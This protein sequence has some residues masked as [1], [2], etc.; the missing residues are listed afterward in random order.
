MLCFTLSYVDRQILSFLIEPMKED[1]GL[2][3]TQIGP[4]PGAVLRDPVHRVG[5]FAGFLADRFSRRNIIIF[6][7]VFWSLM[8]TMSCV[9]RSYLTLSLARIGLGSGEAPLNPAPFR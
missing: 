4:D 8:T 3:D 6:G 1:L 7:L 9:A 5:L 2:S